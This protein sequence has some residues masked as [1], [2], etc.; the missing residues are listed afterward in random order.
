[1]RLYFA[2]FL[3]FQTC[4][5]QFIFIWGCCFANKSPKD[6]WSYHRY[7]IWCFEGSVAI[8]CRKFAIMYY[9]NEFLVSI[10]V[11]NYANLSNFAI[12]YMNWPKVRLNWLTRAFLRNLIW[13]CNLN[14]TSRDCKVQAYLQNSL[15]C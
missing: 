11:Y 15:F 4:N 10:S 14:P 1:M 7:L 6:W 13:K 5:Q 2:Y 3:K 8:I 9:F 12:L